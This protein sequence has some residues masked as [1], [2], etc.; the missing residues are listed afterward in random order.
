M[1]SLIT[2]PFDIDSDIIKHIFKQKFCDNINQENPPFEVDMG[3]LSKP[4]LDIMVPSFQ[5]R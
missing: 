2:T 1:Y 5:Y 4:C 3:S